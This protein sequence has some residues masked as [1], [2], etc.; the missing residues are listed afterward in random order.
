[1][2][3][4]KLENYFGSTLISTCNWI[5]CI[6]IYYLISNH[7]IYIICALLN[8]IIVEMPILLNIDILEHHLESERAL[9]T[10]NSKYI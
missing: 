6:I 4:V 3:L 9:K 10:T 5:I 7:H 1:M 2:T 8:N